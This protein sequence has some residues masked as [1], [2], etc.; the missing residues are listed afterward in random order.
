MPGRVAVAVPEIERR[1]LKLP[2]DRPCWIM[3]DEANSD[4][5]PGSFH[6]V[7]LETHPLRYAYGRFSSAFVR[8]VLRTMAEAIRAW[9]VRMVQRER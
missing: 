2:G 5:M 3:L 7:P 9:Q 4:V 6:L 8:I 1:R